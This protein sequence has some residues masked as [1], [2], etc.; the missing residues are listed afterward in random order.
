M[1]A[2]TPWGDVEMSSQDSCHK[3]V[4]HDVPIG[5]TFA[6]FLPDVILHSLLKQCTKRGITT[7]VVLCDR[8]NE[9]VV[10]SL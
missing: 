8:S 7:G 10:V 6:S 1:Y 3:P 5:S 4:S 9:W 2:N